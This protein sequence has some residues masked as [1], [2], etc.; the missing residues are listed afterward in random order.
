MLSEVVPRQYIVTEDLACEDLVASSRQGRMSLERT[1]KEF[2]SKL[3]RAMSKGNKS[4]PSPTNSLKNQAKKDG[5]K[6][7]QE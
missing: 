1:S 2:G 6:C 4:V 5:N 3:G 7:G